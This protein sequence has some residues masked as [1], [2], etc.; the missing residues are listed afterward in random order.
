MGRSAEGGIRKRFVRAGQGLVHYRV[1]GAGPAVVLLHDS[2][3]SSRLHLETIA[4]LADRFEVF[5][6]DTPG[7]GN[8]TPLPIAAPTIGDFG[9]A[10]GEVLAALGLI[11]APLYA[12][13]TSAK[14]ALDYAAHAADPPPLLLLD[15]LSIPE[16]APDEAFIGAYMRP[17]EIDRAGAYLASEWTRM[18][19]ML[20]WFPWFDARPESRMAIAPPTAAWTDAYMLDLL[21][22]GPHYSDAYAAAMRYDPRAALRR[23]TCQTIVAAK[24]DDV[25]FRC[26]D[27]L[28][29]DTSAS[30][31]VLRLPA[32]RGHWLGWLGTTLGTAARAQAPPAKDGDGAA[33]CYVDLPH[34]QM[35]VRRAG[36]EGTT[37]LLILETPTTL[38]ARLWKLA[39]TPHRA[40]LVPDLPG[41]GESDPLPAADLA[42]HA[43]A[44]AAMLDELAVPVVDLL[45]IGLAAPLALALA[46]RHP[47]R[48]GRLLFDGVADPDPALAAALFPTF[49]S[50]AAGEHLHRIWHMLRDGDVQWP[51]FDES[52]AAQRRIQPSLAAMPLHQALLDILKQPTHYADAAIAG[53]AVGTSAAT[54]RHAAILFDVPGDPGY[55]GVAA[56]A[57]R[58]GGDVLA[59]PIDL[60][61]AATLVAGLLDAEPDIS[62]QTADPIA[63]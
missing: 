46:D 62:L 34:G 26:L 8:S 7:Y 9:R 27:L 17:M 42:D 24:A 18:R 4:A 12:T 14:I 35:L 40:T 36:P 25:L 59:R 11:G 10:L 45:A 33:A 55:A 44:L 60:A 39:L 22:A 56:L 54:P 50:V 13:H 29:P 15:G 38:H 3:R 20:R 43:D 61:A 30:V 2:P 63:P 57:D 16:H 47:A 32:D 51:W 19:D 58:L 31:E 52:V 23:V 1:A 5:A 53:L 28:P 21:S 6:L 37:P 49:R 48:V 41:Y